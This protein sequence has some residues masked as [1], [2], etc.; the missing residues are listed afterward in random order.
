MNLSPRGTLLISFG[1]ASIFV[2]FL[3]LNPFAA[4]AACV[5]FVYI[6]LNAVHFKRDIT[7]IG[8]RIEV[9]IV[10]SALSVLVDTEVDLAAVISISHSRPAKVVAFRLQT[11]AQI[12]VERK[13]PEEHLLRS[14]TA[15]HSELSLKSSSPG[16]FSVTRAVVTLEDTFRLFTHDLSVNCSVDIEI[17]PLGSKLENRIQLGSI[18]Q[19]SRLG[20]GTDLATIREATIL[21]DFRSIDW[22]STARTGKFIVKE[23]YPETDPAVMLVVDK[24]VMTG[25]GEL[26]AGI[27][28]QLG[29]LAITFGASTILGMITYDE[30]GIIDQVLPASG[31][32]SRRQ[33]LRSLLTTTSNV[34]P[35]SHGFTAL[36]SDLVE[37]IRLMKLISINQP[38]GRVDI[39]AR[40]TL[41]YYQSMAAKH[42][43]KL[44]KSGAFRALETTASLPPSLIIVVSSLDRDLSGLCEGAISANAAGHR[45]II[46]VI[47][48]A[49][50]YLPPEL[51]ALNELG[52]QVR[53]SGGADLLNT[54]CQAVTDIPKIRIKDRLPKLVLT[55][56]H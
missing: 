21:T 1:A 9:K 38:L 46:A 14:G 45:V 56:N 13:V 2:G 30:G 51:S 55:P 44:L 28:V 54:I 4:F 6:G 42:S 12:H 31:V 15:L 52:I 17:A 33:I 50:D 24:R 53:Q 7:A 39:Y 10:P 43:I 19:A 5:C 8:D 41:P 29:G 35:L 26:E 36:Y 25:G 18:A 32:Q 22:K 47:G 16:Q 40:D 20:T 11:P 37:T 34:P 3:F 49:R 48:N 23:F 27:L